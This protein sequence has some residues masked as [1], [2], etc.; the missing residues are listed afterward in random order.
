MRKLGFVLLWLP[1]LGWA[2]EAPDFSQDS[3]CRPF[4]QELPNIAQLKESRVDLHWF[5]GQE[6]K[7]IRHIEYRSM[8]VFDENDPDENNRLY[9]FVNKLHL[10]TRPKV[11]AAQLL[12]KPG[13]K[14]NRK[15]IQESARILR[16]RP[17]LS[18]AYIRPLT[19]CDTQIDI[20]V[21]TQDSWS[22]EPQFSISK[23][24][25]GTTKGF[26]IAD[27]NILGTGS[28]FLVGYEENSQRNLV[29][30]QF[31]NPHIFNSQISTKLFYA[32]TS[33]G[34]NTIFELEHPFYALDTPWATGIYQ[35]DFTQDDLIRHMDEQINSFVHQSV[36]NSV[37]YGIATDINE[38]YTQR[39]LIGYSKEEDSFYPNAD[40]LQSVPNQR[41]AN[42]PWIE[43]QYLENR[44]GIYKNV[45]QIQRPEDLSLGHNLL[46]RLGFGSETFD[47]T[48]DVLRYIA[49][50]NYRVDVD[51]E[52]V[53]E[54]GLSANG[55]RH[56]DPVYDDSQ[57][58]GVQA[59]YHYFQTS[60]SRWYL[61]V[62]YHVGH[63]LAQFEELTLGDITGMR[64]YPA[65]FQRGDKRYLINLE[66]RY[67]TD[68]HIF[69]LA[70][71]GAV[72]FYDTGKTWGVDQYGKSKL[73]SNV[74]FGLR[75]APTKVRIGNI[76]HLDFAVPTSAKSGADDYQFTV[77]A[78]QKF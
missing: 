18:N 15:H 11:V 5:D 22:L 26:A 64:G 14:L 37:Y 16:G 30:Y 45:N 2:E 28:S 9:R 19:I 73:L 17:Y 78:F 44:F 77:G 69:N 41:L 6:D 42:Y 53:F 35:E 4:E 24:S 40:T 75:F 49:I 60:H 31:K 74:G 38:N 12:F 57:V 34:K 54:A 32:D 3:S 66:R 58:Y 51:E 10:N 55:R 67:F 20:L 59:A 63:E 46:V 29:R 50:Y 71:L 72:I 68:I 36:K 56:T 62:Q 8:P 27:G 23:Q 1:C 52:H 7:T 21:V 39:W 70:R 65:D 47:N 25:E 48:D 61:G 76:V 43:Y 13:D 33:D